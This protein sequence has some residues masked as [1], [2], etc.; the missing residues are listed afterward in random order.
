MTADLQFVHIV[1]PLQVGETSD[2]PPA[3]CGVFWLVSC[4]AADAVCELRAAFLNRQPTTDLLIWNPFKI[5]QQS[6]ELLICCGAAANAGG[7]GREGAL[8]FINH[9]RVRRA[10]LHASCRLLI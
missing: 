4:M 10:A 2:P 3:L 7:G 5:V 1:D 6:S 9:Q 8:S